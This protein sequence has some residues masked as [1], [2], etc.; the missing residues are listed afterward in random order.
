MNTIL[1][2]GGTSGIGEVF[3]KRFQSMGKKVIITGRRKERLAKLEKEGFGTY[4]FDM[5][6]L[7]SAASHVEKLFSTYP[8]IDTVW[9]NGGI[10][11]HFDVTDVSSIDDKEIEREITTNYMAPVILARHFIP[12]LLAQKK[13]TQL[14]ITSSGLGFVPV[15]RMFPVYCSTKAGIHSYLV[16]L[17]QALSDTQVNVIELVP[18]FVG[19]TEIVQNY[20]GKVKLPPALSLQDFVKQVFEQLDNT[21]AKELKEVVAGTSADRVNGW[22]S[23]ID[24]LLKKLELGG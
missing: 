16:G 11:N 22:R 14:M 21:P 13:E 23:G 8:D 24:P 7:S 10:Q 5:A 1:I 12:R 9:I 3:A 2:I 15:G 6:D 20:D 4:A 19:D 17:R 18:P